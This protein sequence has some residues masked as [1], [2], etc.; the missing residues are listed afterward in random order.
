MSI[1]SLNNIRTSCARGED[2]AALPWTKLHVFIISING[3]FLECIVRT[4]FSQSR[5]TIKCLPITIL[6]THVLNFICDLTIQ[7]LRCTRTISC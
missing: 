4:F 5:L 6:L 2:Y 7:R 3:N 1:R